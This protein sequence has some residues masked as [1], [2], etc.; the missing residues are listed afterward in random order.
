MAVRRTLSYFCVRWLAVVLLLFVCL[1]EPAIAILVEGPGIEIFNGQDLSGWVV[2]GSETYRDGDVEKPIWSVVDGVIH[3]SGQGF[4]F[5]RYDKQVCD[6]ELQLEFRLSAQCNTGVGLR[7]VKYTG[8]HK[9]RPSRSGIEIQLNGDGN[10]RPEKK[11]T[12]S[13]YLHVPPKA[14]P[15]KPIGEWNA[16][17][18]ECRGPRIRVTMNGELIQD[19]DQRKVK[20]MAAKPLCGYVSLQCHGGEAAFRNIRLKTLQ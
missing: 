13:L 20:S 15:L 7:H 6:F 3:S 5:L 2:D 16:I 11:S 12:G 4:G 14:I 18:I 17:A 1:E 10:T 19:V 8:E 9:T